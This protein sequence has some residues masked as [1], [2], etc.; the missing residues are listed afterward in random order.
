MRPLTAP[1]PKFIWLAIL[2]ILS[3]AD[4]PSSVRGAQPIP[5][6]A[7]ID[8]LFTG[9]MVLTEGVAVAPDGHVYFGDI[10]VTFQSGPEGMELGFIPTEVPTNFARPPKPLST[11]AS[12]MNGFR[13]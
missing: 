7:R 8:T 5:A 6:D 3:A 11:V 9:G 10:T 4:A 13:P 1:L 12:T 2:S